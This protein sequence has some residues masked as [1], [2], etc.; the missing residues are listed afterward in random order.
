MTGPSFHIT[1]ELPH[2]GTPWYV[3]SLPNGDIVTCCNQSGTSSRGHVYVWTRDPA[4]VAEK[5]V[6][7]KFAVDMCPPESASGSGGTTLGDTSESIKILG[8]YDRRNEFKGRYDGA[9]AYFAKSDRTVWLCGW[10]DAASEWE[11]VGEVQGVASNET[12]DVQRMVTLDDTGA[13]LNLK[14]NFTDDPQT[15]ARNF[16]AVNGLSVEHLETVR[17]FVIQERDK[18]AASRGIVVD[19]GASI[20]SAAAEMGR[21]SKGDTSQSSHFPVRGF[22][23][24]ATGVKVAVYVCRSHLTSS[25]T[26]G[27]FCSFSVRQS[28]GKVDRTESIC[29]AAAGA[30]R[31]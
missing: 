17:S 9:I 10:R 29:T 11:D 15:V 20:M 21:T 1:Q 14:F 16:L 8:P 22:Q 27:C 12:Y 13:A 26:L 18:E 6:S 23:S 25:S 19:T 24:A 2:P 30:C 5:E 31:A 7:E 3:A 28:P 4:R